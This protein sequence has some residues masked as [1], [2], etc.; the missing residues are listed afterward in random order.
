MVMS[1][2]PPSPAGAMAGQIYE[3]AEYAIKYLGKIFTD[4]L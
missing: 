1:S 3:D 2:V 4:S